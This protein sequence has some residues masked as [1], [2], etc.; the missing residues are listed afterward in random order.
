LVLLAAGLVHRV[1]AQTGALTILHAFQPSTTPAFPR[2]LTELPD[3]SV[4]LTSGSGSGQGMISRV[5]TD[6][7]VTVLHVFPR[8]TTNIEEG[9]NGALTAGVDGYF[10]G[11]TFPAPGTIFRIGLDGAFQT[12][13]TFSGGQDGL[14]AVRLRR[15]PDGTILASVLENYPVCCGP[16]HIL[17]IGSDGT[18]TPRAFTI[19]GPM[20]AIGSDGSVLGFAGSAIFRRSPSSI[21]STLATLPPTS[22]SSVYPLGDLIETSTG[23]VVGLADRIGSTACDVFRVTSTALAVLA[24]IGQS[25]RGDVPMRLK[26]RGSSGELYGTTLA[27]VFRLSTTGALTTLYTSEVRPV[28]LALW[29]SGALVVASSQGGPAGG[30]QLVSIAPVGTSSLLAVLSSGN[31]DG[32]QPEGPV[33]QDADGNIYGTTRRGGAFDQGTIYQVSRT[34]EFRT[35]YTF[36]GGGDGGQPRG[37]VQLANGAMFGSTSAGDTHTGTVFRV[38]RSGALTTL[39]VFRRGRNG[40]TPGPLVVGRDGQLYGRTVRAGLYD[41]GTMFRMTEGGVVTVLTIS[42]R[43]TAWRAS[44]LR[45][46]L[47]TA[48]TSCCWRPTGTSLGRPPCA[49][50]TCRRLVR[51]SAS[52]IGVS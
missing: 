14:Y 36:T 43:P 30:G 29:P 37:L 18:I 22:Y 10:Y 7:T 25:C 45:R 1:D 20:Y 33:V 32:V 9:P 48:T 17:T 23:D 40:D 24:T 3:G 47:P 4:V 11:A 51:S 8:S 2:G 35:I 44:R 31:P 21:V 28:D 49:A 34:G 42:G 6:G 5:A 15:A 41:A 27:S 50:A 38:G 13:C 52:R 26:E 16:Y 46:R 12:V 19:P 39:A